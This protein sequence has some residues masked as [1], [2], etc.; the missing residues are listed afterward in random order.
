MTRQVH[1]WSV[2]EAE[3]GSSAELRDRHRAEIEG[4]SLDRWCRVLVSVKLQV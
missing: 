4:A 3:R 2:F 1:L